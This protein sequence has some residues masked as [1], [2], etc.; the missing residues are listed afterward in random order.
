MFRKRNR[1]F[2]PI[3]NPRSFKLNWEN[4]NSR[5][6]K[7]NE[8]N[9]KWRSNDKFKIFV[10][11]DRDHNRKS[12]SKLGEIIDSKS[13]IFDKSQTKSSRNRINKRSFLSWP[14]SPNKQF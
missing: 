14:D 12:I 5:N 2:T 4:N 6:N 8:K 3:Q 13:S 7:I 1:L 11:K 9:C 10:N